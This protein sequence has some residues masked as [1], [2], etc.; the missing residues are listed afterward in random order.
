MVL[1]VGR[2]VTWKAP[3]GKLPGL[4]SSLVLMTL[5]Q[6]GAM[7]AHPSSQHTRLLQ[8]SLL[9][10]LVQDPIVVGSE[11]AF[12][13]SQQ[14]HFSDCHLSGCFL[15]SAVIPTVSV[16]IP[17]HPQIEPLL[18]QQLCK[19]GTPGLAIYFLGGVVT[20]VGLLSFAPRL[21]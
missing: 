12:V 20:Q 16:S 10:W 1:E 17:E 11:L 6:Y 14:F 9:Q 3:K 18:Q 5:L 13:L 7:A 4:Q 19:G 15:S 8:E 21:G 2:D